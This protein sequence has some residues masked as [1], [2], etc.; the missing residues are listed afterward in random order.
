MQLFYKPDIDILNIQR[1]S[2]IDLPADEALHA[3]RV[4]RNVV[5]DIVWITNGKGLMIRGE[6]EQISKRDCSIIVDEIFTNYGK[7]S[8]Y[9]HAVVAPTKNM[10]RFEWFLEKATE[11]GIDEITPLY[12]AHSERRTVNIDRLEKIITAAVK[13]SLKA[14]H[15]ILNEP[16]D[17]KKFVKQTQNSKVFLAHLTKEPQPLLKMAALNHHHITIVIGPEGDFSDDEIVLAKNAGFDIVSLGPERLRT[18]T[19]ALAAVFTANLINL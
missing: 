4:L 12:T 14:F 10:N 15:P 5:G 2:S 7:R 6:I 11:M 17:F 9:I 8:V 18:E 19:A 13:Q 1:G 3:I 16:L